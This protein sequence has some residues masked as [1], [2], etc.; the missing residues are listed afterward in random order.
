MEFKWNQGSLAQNTMLVVRIVTRNPSLHIASTNVKIKC[1][2]LI[3][4]RFTRR[5]K[6]M[7]YL[8]EPEEALVS[9]TFSIQDIPRG[10]WILV[11]LCLTDISQPAQTLPYELIISSGQNWICHFSHCPMP[12]HLVVKPLIGYLYRM[13]DF[14][15]KP[16]FS[17]HSKKV[18]TTSGSPHLWTSEAPPHK[19]QSFS[20]GKPRKRVRAPGVWGRLKSQP[21]TGLK[22]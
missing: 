2:K 19:E 15:Y 8:R 17:K 5:L 16:W 9:L 18:R 21:T 7:R 6:V 1:G 11:N 3:T 10:H 14:L 20:T 22:T 4:K 12:L 13:Q